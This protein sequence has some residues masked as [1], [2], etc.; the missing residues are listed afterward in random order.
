[1]ARNGAGRFRLKFNKD[2]CLSP[3]AWEALKKEMGKVEATYIAFDPSKPKKPPMKPKRRGDLGIW[4]VGEEN[5]CG[6]PEPKPPTPVVL[7]SF[8]RI[9]L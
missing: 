3:K 9:R 5:I 1:M 2:G 4:P 7:C 8:K 6:S